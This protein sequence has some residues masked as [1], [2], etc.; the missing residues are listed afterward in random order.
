M[1]LFEPLAPALALLRRIR[2]LTL[3]QISERTGIAASDL[4][5]FET[6][7]QRPDL[8]TLD[9][10]LD[11]LDARLEHLQW[12]LNQSS[13]AK[14]SGTCEAAPYPSLGSPDDEICESSREYLWAGNSPNR[15]IADRSTRAPYV[16]ASVHRRRF[17]ATG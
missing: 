3:D 5:A 7:D 6:A 11:G 16:W 1:A 15:K 17:A 12:A 10:L 2:G 14:K 9:R 13:P 4:E 8:A